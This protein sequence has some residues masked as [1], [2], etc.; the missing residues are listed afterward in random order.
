[1]DLSLLRKAES[2]LLIISLISGMVCIRP[3]VVNAV[4]DTVI[5]SQ[6]YGGGGNSGAQYKNDYIELFNRGTTPV[7][8]N[9]WSVQYASASG[10]AWQVTPLSGVL[11]PGQ[12]Y[13][14]QQASGSGG[15]LDLPAPD[16]IGSIAMS[17]TSGKVALVNSQTALS[18][19]CPA[20]VSIIDLVGYGPANCYEGR[21]A[22]SMSNTS[23]ARRAQ[24]GC[25]DSDDNLVDFSIAAPSPRNSTFATADCSIVPQ[26]IPIYTIQGETES[27]PLEGDIVTTSGVVIGDFEGSDSLR[28]FYLQ[29][30]I[31]DN[32]PLTSDGIF[33]YRGD[34]ADSVQIGQTVRVSGTVR[35]AF[36]QTQLDL[37]EMI[38]LDSEFTSIQPISVSLPFSSSA[39]PERY[40]GMLVHFDQTLTVTDTYFLG[41]FGQVTL[42]SGGRLY[43]PTQLTL[44]GESALFLQQAND[45]NR[46][47]L[48][49]APQVQ[50]PDP[51]PFGRGGQPL[52]AE[53][54]LRSGDT[55]S[56]LSGVM[57]YTWGGHSA[58]P[59]AWR[60]RP[61]GAMASD[62][63]NFQPAN[64]RPTEPPVMES[65]LRIAS[66]NTYNYFN[67][68]TNCRAG[69]NGAAV[70]CRGANSPVEFE[71]QATKL[72]SA[73]RALDA[74]VIALMEVE[75]DGYAAE[76][77]LANLTMRL[78]DTM[79]PEKQYAI[80][81]VDSA[82]GKI[83]ALGTDAVRVALL[84]R[85]AVV[86]P[87][88]TAVL[89][90]R[91]F[92]YGGD[93]S[94]RNRVSLL[95]AFAENSTGEQFLVN[96]NHLKSKGSPCDTPD[97]GDGQG[98]CS[99][100]RLNAVR[101][102][103][104]WL[105]TAPTGISDPDILILGDL[106]AYA[107][108]DALAWLEQSGYT[109]LIP[110]FNGLQSYSYVFEGQAG[111]LDHALASATLVSQI[112]A[113]AEWHINADEPVVLDYN[114]EYKSAGQQDILYDPDPFRS[115]D[116]DPLIIGLNLNSRQW[117]IYL[118]MISR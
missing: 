73:L 76:S 4:S 23:A 24:N 100:V 84:Y 61:I 92:V 74:D 67:T 118:P 57:T 52:T 90:S 102:L 14:I 17:A 103:V 30:P 21:P 63:P 3:A 69:L 8:L 108:E 68:F 113:A 71:R 58:S 44:P 104:N 6:I 50:N 9:G 110:Y 36:G 115:S 25:Q 93:S 105:K 101:E 88:A 11:Q 19:A 13:L 22:S 91:A 60:I 34:S 43:Q 40:E 38:I 109:N 107:R 49:D 51:I 28:G 10:S 106:N 112:S 89:D 27:S 5:I 54:T 117:S 16:A 41:R 70:A 12:Y 99:V 77:A 65:R 31:G 82:S 96:V 59:N 85:R 53:N 2:I 80:V 47:L 98:N 48:D 46:I 56:S 18:G 78:N 86:T 32:N 72:V 33:I 94:P 55:I 97:A 79:P 116:H 62:L 39:E 95:Q 64:P 29:D 75:N 42:S 7:S 15:T 37:S 20:S 114:L 87:L 81:D 26:I 66:M 111:A 45:L 35:E 83:N 1:V